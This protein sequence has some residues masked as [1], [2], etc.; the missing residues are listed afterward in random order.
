MSRDGS[1][2]K[3]FYAILLLLKQLKH[4]VGQTSV[5][6]MPLTLGHEVNVS[7][8]FISQSSDFASY[9]CLKLN[10]IFCDDLEI[11]ISKII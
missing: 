1:F 3:C 4:I 10:I 7:M 11:Y 2:K 6:I 9:L 8:T 5:N